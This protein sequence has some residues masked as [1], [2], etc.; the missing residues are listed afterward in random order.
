MLL[1][2]YAIFT[3]IISISDNNFKNIFV[4]ME[5]E[6][7]FYQN[8]NVY[9]GM[10]IISSFYFIRNKQV[11]KKYVLFLAIIFGVFTASIIGGRG[12]FVAILFV[13]CIYI[14]RLFLRNYKNKLFIFRYIFYT[15]II[16]ITTLIFIDKLLFIYDNALTINRLSTLFNA[17][18]SSQRIYLFTNAIE[19]FLSS[20]KTFLFGGGINS[21]PIYIKSY[22]LG[23]YPH[24][25][26]LE[27]LAE[28][29]IFGFFLFIFPILYV[30]YKRKLSGYFIYCES[31]VEDMVIKMYFV[32]FW[33]LAQFTGGLR[34][35]WVLIF[36]T[37]LLMPPSL[38]KLHTKANGKRCPVPTSH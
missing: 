6:G 27:L 36:F 16:A 15:S 33:I 11:I 5:L 12:G 26:I 7:E 18:D 21:F 31:L 19:L 32:Y 2:M 28:Y 13:L 17:D 24:N 35:S 22:S 8:I 30:F 23:M 14:I 34:Y 38:N 10:F 3:G 4:N 25:V 29:G 20:W 1:S 9:I 37:F